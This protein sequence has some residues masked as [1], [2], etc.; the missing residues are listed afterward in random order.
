[1]TQHGTVRAIR[2]VVWALLASPGLMPHAAQAQTPPPPVPGLRS[3]PPRAQGVPKAPVADTPELTP[4][5]IER[6]IPGNGLPNA[7]PQ[8]N[9]P[10]AS[11]PDPRLPSSQSGDAT[12]SLV[13]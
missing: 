5:P 6:E 8:P 4:T 9:V 12:R 2:A 7:L 11:V 10:A 1:M 13:R 3:Q